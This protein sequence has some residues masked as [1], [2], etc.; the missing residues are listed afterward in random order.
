MLQSCETLIT[1]INEWQKAIFELERLSDRFLNTNDDGF[2][3]E[4]NKI[5]QEIKKFAEEYQKLAYPELPNGEKLFWPEKEALI[6]LAQALGRNIET[7]F[8]DNIQVKN[9]HI[10][11][12]GLFNKNLSSIPLMDLS[13]FQNLKNFH[14]PYTNLTIFPKLS[15]SIEFVNFSGNSGIKR[16]EQE[17]IKKEYPNTKILF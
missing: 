13:L 2:K 14:A 16:K 7:F 1:K 4:I 9:G 3:L 11:M 6:E 17:R 5:K 8:K 10:I 15:K 12:I